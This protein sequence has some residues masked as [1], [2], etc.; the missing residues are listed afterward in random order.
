MISY[1]KKLN[2]KEQFSPS[3]LGIFLNPF[4]YSRKELIKNVNSIANNIQGRV[5]DIGCGTKP[6]KPLFN[7]TEYI[8]LEID[9][10]EK[11]NQAI[12]DYFYEG[13]VFPFKDNEFDCVVSFQVCEHIE[14]LDEVMKEIYRVL[15]PGGKLL[16]SVPFVWE[17]HEVP[18]DFRRFTSF[19][20]LSYLKKFN[21]ETTIHLKSTNGILAISQM[22]I[23]NL[24]STVPSN[25][26]KKLF[27]ILILLIC[28]MLNLAALPFR[29]FNSPNAIYLDN[30]VLAEKK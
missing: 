15:K 12:A 29:A 9:T 5:L 25:K 17:E 28:S 19:G 6:Y 27:R 1:L 10:P 18:H 20:L 13:K 16:I 11:R 23:A 4:Y 14:H 2:Q 8:G 7:T 30:I 26:I 24:E 21:F 3:F 22:L